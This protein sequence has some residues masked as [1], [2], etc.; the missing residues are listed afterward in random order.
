M[1]PACR[2][3]RP[4][5]SLVKATYRQFTAHV[6]ATTAPCSGSLKETLRGM[7]VPATTGTVE[8]GA[9]RAGGTVVGGAFDG[10]AD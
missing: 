6:D 9:G 2:K 8:G 4:P 3:V 5:S 7:S 10:A 1:A